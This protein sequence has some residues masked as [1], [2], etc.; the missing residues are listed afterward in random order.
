METNYYLKT[1]NN[2]INC[3]ENLISLE[4]KLSIQGI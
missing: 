4:G 1:R 3:L 2:Y